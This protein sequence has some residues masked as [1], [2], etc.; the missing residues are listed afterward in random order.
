MSNSNYPTGA[1]TDSRAPWNTRE[2]SV[3][4][5]FK[6]NRDMD[7]DDDLSDLIHAISDMGAQACVS[8]NGWSAEGIVY[9]TI[10]YEAGF[11]EDDQIESRR[12]AIQEFADELYD[13]DWAVR[14][15]EIQ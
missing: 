7:V 3:S 6:V 14:D 9:A 12:N 8:S 1:R 15:W 2:T 11:S 10:E 5:E 13:M 4:V